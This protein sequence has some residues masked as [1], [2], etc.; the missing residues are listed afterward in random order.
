MDTPAAIPA[1]TKPAPALS[2]AICPV[3]DLSGG[4]F[5][6]D[7]AAYLIG[8]HNSLHHGGSSA[9]AQVDPVIQAGLRENQG[10]A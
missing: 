3:C 6:P 2:T 4:P 7:E 9:P 5:E 10:R 8:L 1:A